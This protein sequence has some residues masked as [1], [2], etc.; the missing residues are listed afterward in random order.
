MQCIMRC[1][2][3][4]MLVERF[5]MAMRKGSLP[6]PLTT[7][8]DCPCPGWIQLWSVRLAG[9]VSRI[10]ARYVF[11]YAL[12]CRPCAFA[13]HCTAFCH[14]M[15]IQIFF[16]HLT[17]LSGLI[18]AEERLSWFTTDLEMKRSIFVPD[19]L[20]EG[21]EENRVLPWVFHDDEN[22]QMELKCIM[23]G[24]NVSNNP[25]DYKEARWSHPGFSDSQVDKSVPAVT[26]EENGDPYAIWTIKVNTSRADAGKKWVTCEFQQGDFPLSTDF[27]FLIFRKMYLP[28]KQNNLTYDFGGFLTLWYAPK[29]FCPKN[30]G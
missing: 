22:K 1:F 20:S 2:L 9:I 7:C 26:K 28:E 4:H 17:S 11:F 10:Q 19:N 21:K 25:S 23:R 5:N 8:C 24:Y 13:L 12:Y 3:P 6:I 14:S 15:R 16:L 27:T 30:F 29:M 18:N